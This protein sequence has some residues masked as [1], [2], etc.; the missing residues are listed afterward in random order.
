MKEFIVRVLAS[1]FTFIEQNTESEIN[2]KF[3][4]G[5]NCG[6]VRRSTGARS[7]SVGDEE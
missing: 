3:W 2:W 5:Q 7:K 4:Q 6:A 1:G